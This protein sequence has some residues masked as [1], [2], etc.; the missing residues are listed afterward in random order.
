MSSAARIRRSSL[1][2]VI[3]AA[4][5]VVSYQSTARAPQSAPIQAVLTRFNSEG[6]FNGVAL[7]ARRGKVVH[8]AA[9]GIHD[10]AGSAPLRVDD[11]FNIGSISKEFSAVALMQL[12]EGGRLDLNAPVARVITD[13]PAWSEKITP[14]QLL[15][16]TSGLPDLRWRSIQSDRDAY[17]DLQRVTEL[18]FEPGTKYGYRYNDVMLRQFIVEKISGFPF[19]EYVEQQIFKLCRMKH[20]ALNVPPDEPGLAHAFNSDREPDATFMPI[21]GVVFATARDLL[22]WTECLHGGR[23]IRS[24]SLELL[25]NGFN[26]QNGGLGRMAWDA[27]QLVEH[28][29]DGQSRNF[30]ALMLT[31]LSREFTIILL[32]NSKRENLE[33]ILKAIE[34]HA[35][36]PVQ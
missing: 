23:V 24:Q 16:Y 33:Q 22:R 8:E 6:N 27:D 3:T 30:E 19:N 1:V 11:L 7:V 36:G 2:V 12:Y 31:D 32:S 25:G 20:A 28:R 9:Y 35:A 13:L 34:P 15:N 5:C 17:A 4:G 29:H 18:E 14:R 21:T 26:P 10:A